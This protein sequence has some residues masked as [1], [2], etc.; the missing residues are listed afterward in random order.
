MNLNMHNIFPNL[1]NHIELSNRNFRHFLENTSRKCETLHT[2]NSSRIQLRNGETH[3]YVLYGA[4]A[5]HF[6]N[7]SAYKNIKNSVLLHNSAL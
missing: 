5:V 4:T 7:A 2:S 3:I 6:C 1:N